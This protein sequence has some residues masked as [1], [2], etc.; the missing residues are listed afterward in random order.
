MT[1]QR[2]T[3][4]GRYPVKTAVRCIPIRPDSCLLACLSYSIS[5][6]VR[7]AATVS[8]NY[9]FASRE[10][11]EYAPKSLAATASTH[12]TRGGRCS[13]VATITP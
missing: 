9:V 11:P 10:L 2:E 3:L 8:F 7:S 13:R 4:A 12:L 1:P 5:F 6:A